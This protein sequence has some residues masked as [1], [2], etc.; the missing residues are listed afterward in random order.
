MSKYNSTYSKDYYAKNRKH[1]LALNKN[2]R[3]KN[4]AKV[5]AQRKAIAK[6]QPER[7]KLWEFKTN[8]HKHGVTLEWYEAK[9]KEQG[10]CAICGRH[11]NFGYKFHV[12]H[13]HKHCP[14]AHGC[15]KC[16]RGLLCYLCNR[17]LERME[18]I[19]NWIQKARSY[20]VEYTG[21]V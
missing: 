6:A 21:V 20:L 16:V 10:G 5:K 7:Q 17:A 8:L 3:T 4:K 12:D 13:N 14:G 19:M 1:I 2:F 15:E 18:K 11:D 9:L